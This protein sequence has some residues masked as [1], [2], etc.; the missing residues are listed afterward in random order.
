MTEEQEQIF[1]N[2]LNEQFR[3]VRA[4][5]MA[6]SAKAMATVI[7]E[8]ITDFEKEHGNIND[9]DSATIA[10]LVG[11]IKQFCEIGI[12]TPKTTEEKEEQTRFNAEETRQLQDIISRLPQNV[13]DVLNKRMETKEEVEDG[14]AKVEEDKHTENE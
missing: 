10:T 6:A 1:R 4:I 7:L 5:A 12:G 14:R 9:L 3:K 2:R 13:Q 11:D 8:K